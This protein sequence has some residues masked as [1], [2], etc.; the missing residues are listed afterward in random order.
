MS[1]A[2]KW[3]CLLFPFLLAAPANPQGII[4]TVAGGASVF[5]GDGGPAV[6]ATLGGVY[7]VAVDPAGNVYT[8]D[9]DNSLVVKITREGALTVIAGNGFS[10]YSGEGLRATG[11]SLSIPLDLAVDDAGNVF[12]AE[13]GADR[14][15]KITPDGII[16]TVA[17][18]GRNLGDNIQATAALLVSPSGIAF[19]SAGNLYIAE[20]GQHRVRRV[21][22]NGVITTV[23]GNASQGFGGDGGPAT[24]ANLNAPSTVAVDPTGIL[25]ITDTG[26]NRIRRV[27]LIS[28]TITTY[29][30][31]G[32]AGFSGDGGPAANALLNAPTGGRFD[33]S[34]NLYF[35][36]GR[37][38]RIR[39]ISAAERNITTIAGDGSQ[40]FSGDGGPASAAVLN[41]PGRVAVDAL[42]NVYIA[43]YM[44]NRVRRI[45]A[46]GA[47]RTIAGSG[48]LRYYGDGG[49]GRGA[50]L[51]NPQALALGPDGAVYV[52]DT[53]NH[54]IRK[55]SGGILSTVA[56]DGVARFS[57]DGGPAQ[58]ASFN[59]PSGLAFDAAGNLYVADSGNNRLRKIAPD[60]LISTAAGDGTPTVLK[61]PAGVAVDAAGAVYIADADNNR[62]R[63]LAGGTLTTVAGT[64]TAGFAGDTQA[65]T[66][67]QLNRP[68]AV[69]VDR[70]GALYIADTDNNRIRRVTPAGVISMVAGDG[71]EGFYG[72]GVAAT[73][74]GLWA[75]AGML[76]DGAGNL[77]IA[78]RRNNRIRLVN[79]AGQ[80]STVAGRGA[81]GFSGDGGPA[82]QAQ[83]SFPASIAL[84]GGDLLIADSGNN[85]IR[86]IFAAAPTLVTSRDSLSFSSKLN[87]PPTAEQNVSLGST[88]PGIPY[89]I[90]L[91][92]FW[93]FTSTPLTGTVPA[94]T[95]VLVDPDGLA[96]G[97]YNGSV[98]IS[99]PVADPPTRTVAVSVTV[100]PGAPPKLAG[101]PDS[102]SYAYGQGSAATAQ[103]L[104]VSNDGSGLVNFT[105]AA[106]S[107]SGTWLSVAPASGTANP[108]VAVPLTVTANPQGLPPGTYTGQ[109]TLTPATGDRLD[110]TVIMT[111]SAIQQTILLSQTGMTFTAVS[112]GGGVPSQNFGVLNIGR[113]VMQWTAAASTLSGGAGWLVVT[114]ASGASDAAS[115]EVPL[116]DVAINAAGLDPGEYYGRVRVTAGAADN[117]PQY[118]TVVLNVLPP[119]SDPG[120]IVRPTGLIFTGAAGQPAPGSQSVLISNVSGRPT[121]FTSGRIPQD[122]SNWYSQQ[123][124]DAS[125][126]P[127]QPTRIVVQPNPSQIKSGIQ[128]GTLTLQFADGTARTVALLLVIGGGGGTGAGRNADGCTPTR[129]FPVPTSLGSGFSVPASWPVTVEAKVVDDCGSPA[130]SGSVVA[131]FSNGDP[132]VTL[133]S[134]KDGRWTGTWQAR[135]TRQQQ[136]TIN[137]AAADP[138][139]KVSGSAQL[140]GNLQPNPT[141]PQLDRVVSSASLVSE[142]PLAPGGLISI[143][144]AG[145]ADGE[146]SSGGGAL[147][148]ELG[149]TQVVIAGTPAP[150]LSVSP[151]RIQAVLPYDIGVNTRYQVLVQQGSKYVTSPPMAVASAQPAIFT[152]DNSG[153]GQGLIYTVAADGT[154]T[155][156]GSAAPAKAGDPIL[157]RCSGLGAVDPLVPAGAIAPDAPSKTVNPVT[158]TIGGQDAAV[159]FAGLLPG[160]AGTYQIQTKV[161]AGVTPGDETPVVITVAGQPSPAV[162]IA[163]R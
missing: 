35:A 107:A 2:R 102:L 62:V 58:S 36:D 66:A 117:T 22:P 56:G 27:N 45:D 148:N 133:N 68:T 86:S 79:P 126:M 120:P 143:F 89:S 18:G 69:A 75:P 48:G 19:D 38:G 100:D 124:V 15:R 118:V 59:G 139:L 12:L 71:R 112:G 77:F 44:N 121:S 155:L 116:I 144:G 34:G 37:G 63:K 125:V 119:G 31:G 74:T 138:A 135:N 55:L 5:R 132:P 103:I 32:T 25:F 43:D 33:S 104:N 158:V 7:G 46:S 97:T 29:A 127:D 147:P 161:P 52:A 99:S 1:R 87:G 122:P 10:G 137:V 80:I 131:T 101:R 85:R 81:A 115:L 105:A 9:R 30:G 109:I 123:P 93:L 140:A 159:T 24:T 8:T 40:G 13:N 153:K 83:I 157:I 60:G 92:G 130:V 73:A 84:A 111:V 88:A 151:G 28:S 21:S 162:T 14:V 54:R 98:T 51:N 106:R 49:P 17:G 134:L 6:S 108:L 96:P 39:M 72:D 78:D 53:D 26:N 129:L 76:F 110:V 113:G 67:A 4:T 47:I 23:A 146:M 152:S 141:P 16:T 95:Q 114:P 20:A 57:G 150:L 64:G 154:Q 90:S 82:A 160:T 41:R 149:G 91:Q 3:Q 70:A 61:G 163:V 128:R 94:T 142:A 50:L 145:L 42:G 136:V 156:A 11:G 65:A